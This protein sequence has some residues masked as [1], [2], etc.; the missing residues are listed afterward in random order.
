[1]IYPLSTVR[2]EDMPR[3]G[4]AIFADNV[5]S[6]SLSGILTASAIR[7][8]EVF[9]RLGR[10]YPADE[11]KLA[12]AYEKTGNQPGSDI[13]AAR[14]INCNLCLK[15]NCT[16]DGQVYYLT[17]VIIPLGNEYKSL[18]RE[19]RLKTR[20][21]ANL[22]ALV[23]REIAYLHTGIP[24]KADIVERKGPLLTIN[25]GQW[26]GLSVREYHLRGGVIL[27]VLRTGR[28]ESMCSIKPER[29]D[30]SITVD[31]FPDVKPVVASI[32]E[33][34]DADT[35]RRY[36]IDELI[37]GSDPQQ[38][39]AES[40]CVIN[41]GANLCMPGYGSYLAT[42]YLGFQN[43]R[44]DVTGIAVSASTVMLHILT[45]VFATGFRGNFLPWI[46]DADKN[47]HVYRTGIYLWGTLPMAFSAG[48]LDSLAVQYAASE[49]LPPFFRDRDTAAAVL[50]LMVPGGGLFYKG[51]RPW[52]WFY[53]FTEIPL[54]AAGCW[55]GSGKGAVVAFSL[56][57]FVKV[58]DMV[59]AYIAKPGYPF[60]TRE[61]ER[62]EENTV[63]FSPGVSFTPEG[64]SVLRIGLTAGFSGR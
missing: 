29:K 37:P 57:G 22:P 60:F 55:I 13:E 56:L 14:A 28:Y 26:H 46:Q 3:Q 52:G 42:G 58:V 21:A 8:A 15:L 35:Y 63:S 54:G 39:F 45:P 59:H 64:E 36:A 11:R 51:H 4:V 23:A 41:P 25:A 7:A 32:D 62:G 38:R 27:N 30:A 18:G 33:E 50:S 10:F 48:F 61:L 44:Y 31:I 47:D 43:P 17:L 53:Y 2:A 5:S 16:S 1:M 9:S 24:L 34:I 49:K 6:A 20:I 40:M 12:A 19:I